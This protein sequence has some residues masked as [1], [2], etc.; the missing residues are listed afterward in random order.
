MR[1]VP[2]DIVAIRTERSL[3]PRPTVGSVLFLAPVVLA[4][5]GFWPYTGSV[6]AFVVGTSACVTLLL[7]FSWGPLLGPWWQARQARNEFSAVHTTDTSG[8]LSID[9]TGITDADSDGVSRVDWRGVV[10]IEVGPARS[11]VHAGGVMLLV[12]RGAFEDEDA[13][14]DFMEK[15]IG[16]HRAAMATAA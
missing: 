10:R 13:Y 8:R 5:V 16:Y 6:R 9:S 1:L 2:E 3:T 12:P 15:M 11:I 7:V 4:A 14:A